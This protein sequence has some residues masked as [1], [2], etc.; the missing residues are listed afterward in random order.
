M[1]AF[2]ITLVMLCYTISAAISAPDPALQKEIDDLKAQIQQM[3]ERLRE[4]E[5]R[6]AEQEAQ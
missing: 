4:L 6:L 2:V 3:T 5:Q 1:R